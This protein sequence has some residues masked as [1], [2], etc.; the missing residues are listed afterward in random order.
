MGSACRISSALLRH[1]SGQ[2]TGAQAGQTA[3]YWL[4]WVNTRGEKGP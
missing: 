1:F 3:Y 2:Y 4:R